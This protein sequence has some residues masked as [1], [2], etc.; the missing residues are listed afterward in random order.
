MGKTK[1]PDVWGIRFSIGPGILL[2]YHN[3][4][5]QVLSIIFPTQLWQ[6]RH[7]PQEFPNALVPVTEFVRDIDA[8]VQFKE[9]DGQTEGGVC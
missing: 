5:I 9:H 4:F 7:P 8:V 2:E 6:D 3:D 1:C